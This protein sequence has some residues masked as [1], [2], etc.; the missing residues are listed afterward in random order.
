M[1]ASLTEPAAVPGHSGICRHPVA[2]ISDLFS[3][4][5]IAQCTKKVNSFAKIQP[6]SADSGLFFANEFLFFQKN[7]CIFFA[8]VV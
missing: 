2:Y 7:T 4:L 3:F 6:L 1:S 8:P 5:I